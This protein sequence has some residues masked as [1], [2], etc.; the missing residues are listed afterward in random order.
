MPVK[1]QLKKPQSGFSSLP[2]TLATLP[3][4]LKLKLSWRNHNLTLNTTTKK[5][6]TFSGLYQ[7]LDF[8]LGLFTYYV[9]RE[10]GEGGFDKF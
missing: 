10:R 9:S 5:K 8:T 4:L 1:L 3:S 2:V 7:L 6:M